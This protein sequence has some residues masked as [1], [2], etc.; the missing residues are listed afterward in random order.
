MD[1]E[2]KSAFA[3]MNHDTRS[4]FAKMDQKTKTEFE[5]LAKMIKVGFDN[6]VT[7]EELAATKKELSKELSKDIRKS[8][9][10][11]QDSV[12]RKVAELKGELVALTRKEDDKLFCLVDKLG[13]KR[14]LNKDDVDELA[15]MKPFP[16]TVA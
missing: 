6:M 10:R 2:T 14:V 13:N 12:S 15:S 3:K 4:L 1:Q 16:R 5:K 9:L 7:K 8:E 11:T